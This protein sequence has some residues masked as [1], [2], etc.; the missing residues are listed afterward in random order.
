MAEQQGFASVNGTR[1]YYESAGS[2]TPLVLVHGFSLDCTMWDDQVAA[3][4]PHHRV[5][6]YDLRGFGQSPA[7]GVPYS[8]V[9]DLE[10]LLGYLGIARA[11][12]LGLSMGGGIAI[13]FALAYPDATRALIPVDS[14]LGGYRWTP[15]FDVTLGAVYATGRRAGV[16]A[17]REQWLAHSLFESARVRPGPWAR[18]GE[19]VT[20]YT[21]WHWVNEDPGRQLAPPALDRL[22]EIAA[23]ALVVV[24]EHDMPDFRGVADVLTT[25][26]RRA[27]LAVLPGVGHMANMED[28][29]RFNRIILD[30]L[31]EVS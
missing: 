25:R 17:A 8:H 29:A 3:F 2:G 18:V 26:I 21:G 9:D 10:A 15:A 7:S 30:F 11:A 4:T 22:E 5:I 13:D 24:G 28:P 23:P 31:E 19:M 27:R 6:R 16:E 20:A 14:T 1:L 12:I